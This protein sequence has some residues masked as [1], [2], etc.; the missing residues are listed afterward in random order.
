LA[1]GDC[2]QGARWRRI[3]SRKYTVAFALSVT[4]GQ[5]MFA[6]ARSNR[7]KFALCL[8]RTVGGGLD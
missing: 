3:E 4:L 7:V 1:C 2:R 6:A 8:Y 5:G